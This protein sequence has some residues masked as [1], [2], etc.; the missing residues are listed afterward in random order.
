MNE[1]LLEFILKTTQILVNRQDAILHLF[2]WQ[3]IIALT[4]P[5]TIL[6]EGEH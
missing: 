3:S 4:I 6:R 2:R 1:P 5:E